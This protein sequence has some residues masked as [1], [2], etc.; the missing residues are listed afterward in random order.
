MIHLSNATE[1]VLYEER[2]VSVGLRNVEGTGDLSS[3]LRSEWRITI[4]SMR[5]SY[6]RGLIWFSLGVSHPT[7]SERELLCMA[8][9]LTL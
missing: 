8:T 3:S 5:L 2:D 7:N 6:Q 4:S 9:G 1:K